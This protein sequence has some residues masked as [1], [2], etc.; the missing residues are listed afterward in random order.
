M[1]ELATMQRRLPSL[2]GLQA[3]EA[4]AR[5]GS[6]T[7]AASELGLTQT[8]VSH[9][10]A[11]LEDQ[12]GL[13][14]FRRNGPRI[15]LTDAART[16]T[17]G[18]AEAFDG[19]YRAT[20]RLRS[21]RGGNTLTIST[22]I[23]FGA[24]WLVP[25]MADFQ[26]RHPD[27]DARLLT[28]SLPVDFA[29]DGVDLAIRYGDGD[30]PGLRADLLFREELLPVCSPKLLGAAPRPLA[31][32][33]L[34]RFRLIEVSTY[35]DDWRN[36][37]TGARAADGRTNAAPPACDLAFDL[38]F[39][40]IEAAM[41]GTGLAIGRRSLVARDLA[42]GRLIAPFAHREPRRSYF[43]VTP[44]GTGEREQIALFREWLLGTLED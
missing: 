40:A 11:R 7:R 28:S 35:P 29:R 10:I 18:V 42:A 12:L 30:W 36:W 1:I 16:Y 6:F 20:Q 14:L 25:R 5:L 3:F 8:A 41:D 32:E 27:I 17:T 21:V 22:L 23:S 34:K 39:A 37:L 38:A 13:R 24:K 19:L 2:S 31:P 9:R 4:V 26:A 43:L 15:A 44:A 33:D